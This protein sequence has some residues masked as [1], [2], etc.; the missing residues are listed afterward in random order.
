MKKIRLLILEDV[1]TDLELVLMELEEAKLGFTYLHVETKEEFKKGLVE[2]N[3]DLILSDYSLP[4]FT[5][6]EALTIVRKFH[7]PCLLLLL[8]EQ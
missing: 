4:Q 7:Q 1:L 6:M 2:F 3:P 5:G 8:P